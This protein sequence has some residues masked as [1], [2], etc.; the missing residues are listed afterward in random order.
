MQC[1]ICKSNFEEGNLIK[2][3]ANQ[4][5][6]GGIKVI[7]LSVKCCDNCERKVNNKI[8]SSRLVEGELITTEESK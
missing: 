4:P 1:E 7:I 6:P 8:S 5:V 3:L 2:L